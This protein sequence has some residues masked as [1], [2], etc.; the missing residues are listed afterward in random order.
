MTHTVGARS[1]TPCLPTPVFLLT[2]L[3]NFEPMDPD[4]GGGQTIEIVARSG[5]GLGSALAIVCSWER[6]KS[7]LWGILAGLLGWLYVI[8]FG[9][10][11]EEDEVK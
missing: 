1:R 2:L 3:Q 7:I 8:Y 4:S 10:T 11:R 5:I 9:L 6:N